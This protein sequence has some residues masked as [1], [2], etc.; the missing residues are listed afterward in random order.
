MLRAQEV[1]RSRTSAF[2]KDEILPIEKSK[3]E[4]MIKKYPSSAPCHQGRNVS[5]PDQGYPHDSGLRG[6]G[7]RP[8]MDADLVY[9]IT[10]AIFTNLEY[11][12]QRHDYYKDTVRQTPRL[13]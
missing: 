8:D 10:K 13:G 9:D 3:M 6:I 5:E 1:R 7:H 12:R 11:L 2:E 4:S